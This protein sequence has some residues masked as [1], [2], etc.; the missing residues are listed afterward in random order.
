MALVRG[1]L[2][3]KFELVRVRQE[4]LKKKKCV[5][6]LKPNRKKP[7]PTSAKFLLEKYSALS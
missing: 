7:P 3:F 6:D 1:P 2:E 5:L 4:N